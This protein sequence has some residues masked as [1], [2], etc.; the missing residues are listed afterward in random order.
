MSR[1]WFAIRVKPHK[2]QIARTQFERQGFT[3]YLPKT[4]KTR[5]HA[6]R[7]EQVERPFFPGYLFL[8][9]APEERRWPT[10]GGTIGAI[11]PVRFGDQYPPVPAWLIE[12]LQARED[13]QGYISTRELERSFLK[14]GSKVKIVY[15]ELA[16]VEGIFREIRGQD[17][18]VILLDMLRRQVTATVSVA[19]LTAA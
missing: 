5:R 13:E 12:N 9:L 6:R 7:V 3:V 8:H 10:I 14:P 19:A 15:G 11:G 16:G 2:E 1:E 18:A 4:L 17:R